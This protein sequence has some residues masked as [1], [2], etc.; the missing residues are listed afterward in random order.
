MFFSTELLTKRDGGFG[1]L[2]L[3]A[4]LGPKSSFNKLPKRS[5]LNADISQLCLLISEPKEPLSL[6]L[7]SNLLVGAARVFR[8]KHEIFLADV[9][10]CFVGLKKAVQDMRSSAGGPS[11]EMANPTARPDALNIS[12]D[13]GMGRAAFDLDLLAPTWDEWLSRGNGEDIMQMSEDGD[14]YEPSRSKSGKTRRQQH[15]AAT[16]ASPANTKA[17]TLNEDHL[18]LLGLLDSS[19]QGGN[20]SL[21]LGGLG[22]PDSSFGRDDDGLLG[23]DLGDGADLG[24]ELPDGWV[25]HPTQA[26]IAQDSDQQHLHSQPF[27]A[28]F[29]Q[30][31]IDADM[32]M[33]DLDFVAPD[34]DGAIFHDSSAGRG[35]KRLVQ[36]TSI[37]VR[38]IS[39]FQSR[40]LQTVD[41]EN[42]NEYQSRPMPTTPSGILRSSIRRNDAEVDVAAEGASNVP[43]APKK[44]S[45]R[46]R[47]LLDATTELTDQEMKAA[48]KQYVAEQEKL[49][50]AE[51][52]KKNEKEAAR[53][54]DAMLWAPPANFLAPEL[55]DFWHDRFKVQ[56][57]ART[58]AVFIDPSA[59]DRARV[60]HESPALPRPGHGMGDDPFYGGD[61]DVPMLDPEPMLPDYTGLGTPLR[62]SATPELGRA[63][64]RPASGL[65]IE[66][67][68]EYPRADKEYG[69]S[70]SSFPWDNAGLGLSSSVMGGGVG[71]SS[72]RDSVRAP[73]L[74]DV[75]VGRLSYSRASGS[76]SASGQGSRILQGMEEDI[77][78]FDG[79]GQLDFGAGGLEG[80][81][82]SQSQ[83]QSYS[84]SQSLAALERNSGNFLEYAKIEFYGLPPGS[85]S[86]EFSQIVRPETSS[87]RVASTGFYHSL[88]L[89]TKNLIRIAQPHPFGPINIEIP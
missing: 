73:S 4:T 10:T 85:K 51:F 8:V 25:E 40:K 16:V 39:I 1:L 66:L 89:A 3:A 19:S 17:H 60:Y 87:R 28:G 14:E 54:I 63:G 44:A 86:I 11:L 47:Y 82:Q 33:M 34:D 80:D 15:K 35:K 22:G 37:K 42:D 18:H 67:G 75:E 77:G 9:N 71:G 52:A 50:Q 29:P 62:I 24:L 65:G 59:H 5:V 81:S 79:D 6:R 69:G 58:G 56:V 68:L 20:G 55:L 7:S 76:P 13:P 31:D 43:T 23:F 32:M 64:S 88:L 46:V 12:E 21:V 70:A 53:M 48:R 74:H 30:L 26:T 38:L 72:Q 84:L 78:M 49:R 57:E 41:P 61:Y 45:K 2:W 27:E 36:M 83:S